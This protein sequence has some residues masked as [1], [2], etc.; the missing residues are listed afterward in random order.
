MGALGYTVQHYCWGYGWECISNVG[1]Y[2]QDLTL[3]GL[4]L[5][6]HTFLYSDL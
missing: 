3:Y 2:V 4:H 6:L 5:S 1:N